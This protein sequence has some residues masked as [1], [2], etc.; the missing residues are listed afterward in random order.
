[1]AKQRKKE[2]AAQPDSN[3]IDVWGATFDPVKGPLLRKIAA[4]TEDQAIDL[5]A[6]IRRKER[7]R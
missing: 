6:E 4:M 1:M 3:Y 7:R 5:L 2:P